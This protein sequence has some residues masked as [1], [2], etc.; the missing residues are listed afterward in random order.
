MSFTGPVSASRVLVSGAV[1]G[2]GFRPFVHRLAA[3]LGLAGN[4]ANGARGVEI[5]VEGEPSRCAAFLSRLRTDAP[6]G[7]R[8]TSVQVAGCEPSGLEA[9]EIVPSRGA[10]EADLALGPDLATC[11]DCR[12]ELF[13]P[14]DRRHRYP[15]TN[16]TSCGPRYTIATGLPYDRPNTTMAGFALCETC[17]EEYETP[18]DRRFHAQPNACP[19]CGPAVSYFDRD[20]VRIGRGEDALTAA[21][22]ALL[23][24]RVVAVKGLGGYHLMVR[25]DDTAAVGELRRRKERGDKPFAVLFRDALAVRRALGR[26]ALAAEELTALQSPEAPIVLVR[27]TGSSAD[28]SISPEVAPGSPDLGCMIASNPLH[29]L[30][31]ADVDVP[32]VATSGNRRDEPICVSLEE[33]RAVLGE[34]A[35]GFLDHD[36]PIARPIDDSIVRVVEGKRLVLRR[37]RGF[38]P[39]WIDGADFLAGREVRGSVDLAVGSQG[40]CTVALRVGERAL[41][42]PHLGD[43]ETA[44]ARDHHE[45]ALED[46]QA[47]AGRRADRILCDR[48]PDYASTLTAERLSERPVRVQHHVAHALAAA[49]ELGLSEDHAALVWDGSGFGDDGTVWGAEAFAVRPQE[50]GDDQVARA[51]SVDAFPL[52]GGEKAVREPWRAALGLVHLAFEGDPP[53]LLFE[54]ALEAAGA[55]RRVD[56]AR[57][58]WS[59]GCGA[60]AA[61]ASSVGRMFDAA[62]ALLGVCAVQEFEADA[63]LR[64]EKLAVQ[65]AGPAG[66]I[67]HEPYA[68]VLREDADGVARL[69][70]ASWLHGLREDLAAG[71]P[72]QRVSLRF[73]D[74]LAELAALQARRAAPAA[75]ATVTLTG[76]CFQNHLLLQRAAARLRSEGFV[77]RWPAE[78]PPNDGAIALGQLAWA[79]T[80]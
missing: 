30:L 63:A 12:S 76:G 18:T 36:R 71:A 5:L 54:R 26:D 39:L 13:D 41:V 75:G 42:S 66:A 53:A 25:A 61:R 6:S 43:L 62:A 51:A 2:V 20:G 58:L 79:A 11:L 68:L 50:S 19:R 70:H 72:A 77:P 29:H 73:H 60:S 7:A 35:D 1:Q 4:V 74:T 3:E 8:I 59:V 67:P 22:D 24:G 56:Q 32:L 47:L 37:A 17:R 9:F 46:L 48:H 78:V 23:D 40:K 45:A 55:A 33:A 27:W 10:G 16:C 34:I 14:A 31:L 21:R 49:F 64:L 57:A 38:A 15:F 52:P 44:R 80:R 28:E 65:W 69:D